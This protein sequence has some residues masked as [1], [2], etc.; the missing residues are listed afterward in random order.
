MQASPASL[1]HTRRRPATAATGDANFTVELVAS[2]D[3]EINPDRAMASV[4][5]VDKDP[6]PVLRFKNF[7]VEVREDIGTAEHTVELVSNLPV[8]RDV[9][10]DYQV[11]EQFVSGRGR[12][13]REYRNPHHTRRRNH[14][15]HR[16]T[17][18][19]GRG[20]GVGRDL[21]CIPEKPGPHHP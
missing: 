15:R 14:R 17:Y 19:P 12:R 8:L 11:Q 16:D 18:H 20:G 10:V 13:Y 3:Y 5:V 4:I 9:T 2:D 6:L 21:L 7:L 1:G